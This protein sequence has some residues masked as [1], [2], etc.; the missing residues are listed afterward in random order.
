MKR[1]SMAFAGLL[2][3][4]SALAQTAESLDL[5]VP[6]APVP[7]ATPQPRDPPGTYYGDTSGTPTRPGQ[8][9]TEGVDDGKAK[10]WGSVTSGIGYSKGYGT[11]HYNAAD[12]NVSK[13]FGDG[14]RPHTVNLQIHVEQGDGP[15]FGDRY[16]ASP[17]FDRGM[18]YPPPR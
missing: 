6:E 3:A 14:E 17:Y 12:L 5:R 4:G 16:Q 2:C 9:E 1:M 13:A 7:T 11:S 10:V 18:D 8:P 15:G